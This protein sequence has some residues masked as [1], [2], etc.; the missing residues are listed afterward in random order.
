M[1]EG[2]KRSIHYVAGG[3]FFEIGGAFDVNGEG[4]GG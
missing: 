2:G 3:H 4:G 1:E